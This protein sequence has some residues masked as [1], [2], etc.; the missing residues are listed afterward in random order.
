MV[1]TASLTFFFFLMLRRPPRSTR[2]DTLFPYTTLFRSRRLARPD[3][4]RYR[5]P[6]IFV[7]CR[8]LCIAGFRWTFA[9]ADALGCD[10]PARGV[11]LRDRR[12]AQLVPAAWIR[13]GSIA[14]GRRVAAHSHRIS[15]LRGDRKST[16]LTSSH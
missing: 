5:L 13:L 4:S 9:A 15:R 10:C 7:H 3:A 14:V 11:A 12:R 2:T 16:R 8:H 6:D 1:D